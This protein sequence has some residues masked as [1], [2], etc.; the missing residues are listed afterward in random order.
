[1]IDLELTLLP[2]EKA[3]LM[4]VGLGRE[5][6]AALPEPMYAYFELILQTT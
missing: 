4:P 5:P 2:K 3:I 6:P 1:M